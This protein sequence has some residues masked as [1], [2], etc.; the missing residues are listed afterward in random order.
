MSTLEAI[1]L[2]IVQG[3]GEFLPISSSGHL[4]LARWLFGWD[5]LSDDLEQ[6]F[7]VAVHIGTLGAVLIYFRTD[8]WAYAK[9][10]LRSLT[11]AGR[12]LTTDARI[13]WLLVVSMIPAA[14]TGVV[15]E[16][17]LAT[18]R[19]WLIAVALIV[20]GLVLYWADRLPGTRSIEDFTLRDALLIGGGQALALQPGVSRSGATIT[21]GR[22]LRFDRAAAARIAFLMSVPVIAGAGLY[23]GLSAEI[24]SD[25]VAPFLWGMAAAGLTGYAAI[26][27]TLWLVQRSSFTPFV[28]YRVVL[29]SVVLVLLATGVR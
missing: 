3:L 24:P 13:A 28:I 19:I 25:F 22:M 11:P 18:D 2:G 12:P 26:W 14:I 6:S 7:D 27:G 21:V 17:V 15:F 4:E 9:A 16:S 5:G 8:L 20:G 10:G 1:V 23:K 29:G